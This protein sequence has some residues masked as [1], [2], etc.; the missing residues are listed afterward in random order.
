MSEMDLLSPGTLLLVLIGAMAWLAAWPVQ[1]AQARMEADLSDDDLV[2]FRTRYIKPRNR[3]DMPTRFLDLAAAKDQLSR[4]WLISAT[5]IL[6]AL[7]W[8]I[9]AGP[10]LG[11]G[12]SEYLRNDR[13]GNLR[14]A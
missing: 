1:K 7:V 3:A 8:I 4:I 12:T 9:V 11:L 10:S 6:G 5:A 14:H 13:Q 2:L